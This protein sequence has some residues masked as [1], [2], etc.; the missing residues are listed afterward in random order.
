MLIW[1]GYMLQE[2]V[3]RY[4]RTGDLGERRLL[5]GGMVLFSSLSLLVVWCVN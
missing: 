1:V 5:L 4:L 3:G 2:L